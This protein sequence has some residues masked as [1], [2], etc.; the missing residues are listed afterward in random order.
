MKET[1]NKL[2]RR[3]EVEIIIECDSNPGFANALKEI[4]KHFKANEEQVVVK[5]ISSSFGRNKFG[6]EANIYDSAKD[7]MELEPKKKEKAKA[8]AV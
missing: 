1:K 6:I 3:R 2:M 4:V 5:R 8:P 7:K